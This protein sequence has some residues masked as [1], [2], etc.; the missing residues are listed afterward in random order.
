P[1]SDANERNNRMHMLSVDETRDALSIVEAA[2][3]VARTY[4][5]LAT[6]DVVASSPAAMRVA[7]PPQRIQIKGAV[8]AHEGIAG[9]RLSS[10]QHPRLILWDRRTTEPILLLEESWLYTFRTGTSGAVVARW[11]TPRPQ[12][13]IALIGA[14]TIA[15]HMARAFIELC[16][17]LS[18]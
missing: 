3:V 13:R 5:A 1:S 15:T 9:A 16:S 17:P 8:L 18:I 4:A 14:G 2:D 11:L 6:G 7:P 10:A 12:P